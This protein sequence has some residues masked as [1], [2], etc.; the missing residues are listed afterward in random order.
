MEQQA[1]KRAAAGAGFGAAAGVFWW[2][3]YLPGAHSLPVLA[4]SHAL[5][6]LVFAWGVPF[7]IARWSAIGTLLAG[8]AGGLVLGPLATVLPFAQGQLTGASGFLGIAAGMALGAVLFLEAARK[9]RLIAGALLGAAIAGLVVF[10]GSGLAARDSAAQVGAAGIVSGFPDQPV[11]ILG[12]DG[13]DFRVID[14]M[15]ERGELPNLE[16]LMRRG[17][18]GV[19]QSTEP[20]LSPVVWTTILSGHAP[21]SHGLTSWSTSDNR[22]RR[23]PMIWDV[24]G[25][26]SLESLVINVPGSWPAAPAEAARILS[27]F[28]IPGIVSGGRGQLLGNV[29]SS[30]AG[31]AGKVST[32]PAE[33][34]SPGRFVFDL[35]LAAPNVRPRVAGL[36]HPLIDAATQD[37]VIPVASD[38]FEGSISVAPGS[39]GVPKNGDAALEVVR[40]ESPMLETA[41]SLPIGDW[42]SWLRVRVSGEAIAY[43]R[44]RVLEA[45]PD[46]LRMI[47]TPAFQD[48]E[49]PRFEFVSGIPADFFKKLSAP[50]VVEGPGWRAHEDPRVAPHLPAVLEDIERLHSE[51]AIRLL[52]ERTPDLFV[53]PLTLVDRIQHPYWRDHEPEPYA[54]DG[55]ERPKLTPQDPVEAAY[56]VSD[57]L[58][59][60]LLETLSEDTLVFVVSDHG[61]AADPAKGEGGHRLEG[62]WIAAGPGVAPSEIPLALSETLSILDLVPTVLHCV[63]APAAADMPG[64]AVTAV[65]P[66]FAEEPRIASYRRRGDAA[67]APPSGEQQ[68]DATREE[69]LR[70]LGYIE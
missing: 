35:P 51:A 45:G 23:V 34:T 50:Y 1:I 12:I 14:P 43:V 37:R 65:C 63:G 32:Q 2:W 19:F 68:I 41:V 66:D 59:G 60:R 69:Q 58:I 22:N 38:R 54:G 20:S 55:F 56:R 53:Y 5:A 30:V 6:G 42:S 10:N 39:A 49:A 52:E 24:Y 18:R 13:G 16:A 33:R 4:L 44:I 48:P 64:R 17:R 25:A 31:E 9:N 28:P 47:L 11:A 62:I 7:V 61:A 26:H 3:A 15:I 67:A 27:G 57:E 46:S 40:L 21:E 70:S 8:L 36:A 29:V